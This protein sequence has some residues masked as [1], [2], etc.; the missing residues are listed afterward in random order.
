MSFGSHTVTRTVSEEIPMLICDGC[1]QR[2]DRDAPKT[3][4]WIAESTISDLRAGHDSNRHFC[5]DWC[6]FRY[7]RRR[8]EEL[9]AEN[10]Q[11]QPEEAEPAP[12]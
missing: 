6:S 4:A 2:T 5:S 11:A 3:D 1:G 9:Q 10:A 8:A 7:H 12:V